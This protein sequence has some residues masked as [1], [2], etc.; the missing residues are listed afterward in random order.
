MLS[1]IKTSLFDHLESQVALWATPLEIYYNNV[2]TDVPSSAHL[3]AFVLPAPT[4]TIGVNE[5]GQEMGIF[6]VNVHVR[7]GVGELTAVEIAEA[8]ITD[9][10]RNLELS[11]VRIDKYGSIAPPF[12]NDGWEITPVSFEYQHLI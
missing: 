4:E 11:G 12:F 3:R 5:L 8:I 9:F 7:K 2:D 1:L 6:Q 10:P